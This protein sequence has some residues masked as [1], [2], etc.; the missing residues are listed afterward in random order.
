MTPQIPIGNLIQIL[1]SVFGVTESKLRE[2]FSSASQ[3]IFDERWVAFKKEVKKQYIRR[4]QDLHPDRHPERIEEA[5]ALN[6][7][8]SAIDNADIKRLVRA[9]QSHLRAIRVVVLQSP[10][11][12]FH[13]DS[14]TSSTTSTSTGGFGWGGYIKVS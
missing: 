7:A 4:I 6:N 13:G 14:T 8:W 11:F 3:E 1:K 9:P 5:K 10:G 12:G 2:L